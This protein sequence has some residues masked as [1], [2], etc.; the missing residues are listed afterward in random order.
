MSCRMDFLTLRSKDPVDPAIIFPVFHLRFMRWWRSFPS[1]HSIPFWPSIG[2]KAY[3]T[4]ACYCIVRLSGEYHGI[5]TSLNTARGLSAA[6]Y[7][8]HPTVQC[9]RSLFPPQ[10]EWA[11]WRQKEIGN[12]QSMVNLHHLFH[13]PDYVHLDIY[14]SFRSLSIR[15]T[16]RK[17]QV[18]SVQ[19]HVF[20]EN[21]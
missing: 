9:H 14:G 20:L 12:K 1:I 18:R 4:P 7:C 17:V 10:I 19:H 2:G 8:P 13:L 11:N 15:F 16:L 3:P 5:T 6:A 21:A